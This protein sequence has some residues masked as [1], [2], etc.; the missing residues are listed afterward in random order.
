MVTLVDDEALNTAQRSGRV[1]FGKMRVDWRALSLSTSK[2][3]DSFAFFRRHVTFHARLANLHHLPIMIT[4]LLG[5]IIPLEK[6]EWSSF[7]MW[8]FELN[9]NEVS[10]D[11]VSRREENLH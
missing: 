4:T 1:Q 8:G 9:L 6:I 2:G 10:G 3:L 7:G 11:T 5:K